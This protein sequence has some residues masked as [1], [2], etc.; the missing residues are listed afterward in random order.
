MTSTG[1]FVLLIAAVSVERMVELVIS[2]RHIVWAKARGGVEV[3]RS[4][5]PAM[6]AI[7][8]WLLVGSVL[9]VVLLGR[10]FLP[11]LGWPAFAGVLLAQALRWWCIA[12]LGP[13]WNTRIVVVPGAG[14]VT[15]GPYRRLRHPNYVAVA[16]EGV[17]LPLVHTA[18]I[19][20]S[21]FTVA[22]ALVLRRRI[23]LEDEALR[24]LDAPLGER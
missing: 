1:W 21:T 10:V 3:G 5:Y 4:H 2:Q 15:R 13:Q 19:T 14:R 8:V 9:E 23:S 17:C 20:A 24:E 18:W 22:N 16:V 7:H 12:T 6:V 11:W